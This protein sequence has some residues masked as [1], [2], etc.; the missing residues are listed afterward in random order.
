MQNGLAVDGHI[1]DN[2][3][4]VLGL[5]VSPTLEEGGVGNDVLAVHH[6]VAG[7]LGVDFAIS[8]VDQVDDFAR[9]QLGGILHPGVNGCAVNVGGAR[10]LQ[11]GIPSLGVCWHV[12]VQ[13]LEIAQIFYRVVLGVEIQ[14]IAGA[15][16]GA[17]AAVEAHHVAQSTGIDVDGVAIGCAVIRIACGNQVAVGNGIAVIIYSL[18]GADGTARNIQGVASS[19]TT[20]RFAANQVLL[21]GTAF[22]RNSIA[23]G[24]TRHSRVRTNDIISRYAAAKGYFVFKHMA[25]HVSRAFFCA[26]GYITAVDIFCGNTAAANIHLVPIGTGISENS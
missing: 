16:G 2:G 22:H 23:I 24:I 26:F 3:V 1:Q 13:G 17:V 12:E 9:V 7:V 11:H 5:N 6:G 19:F 8:V 25:A 18:G 4:G 20:W 15:F 14:R 10:N 21:D